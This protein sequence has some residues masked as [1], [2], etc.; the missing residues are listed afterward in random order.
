M[1]LV[2]VT[3]AVTGPVFGFSEPWQLVINTAT[4]IVTFLMVFVIQNTQNR[5]IRAL[6]LKLDEVLRAMAGARNSLIDL[7]DLSDA[8]LARLAGEFHAVQRAGDA[9]S[10]EP[11]AAIHQELGSRPGDAAQRLPPQLGADSPAPGDGREGS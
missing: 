10:G 1:P 8:K 3:W 6:H 4:T 2:I 11:I 7:E 5:D 9:V